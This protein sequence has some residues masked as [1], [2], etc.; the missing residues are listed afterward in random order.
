MSTRPNRRCKLSYKSGFN[1]IFVVIALGVKSY[2][3]A[4]KNLA[5]LERSGSARNFLSSFLRVYI[6]IYIPVS[7]FSFGSFLFLLF[8]LLSFVNRKLPLTVLKKTRK[9]MASFWNIIRTSDYT[10][11]IWGIFCFNAKGKNQ[12]ILHNL[13]SSDFGHYIPINN[14]WNIFQRFHP[15]HFG[16]STQ[17]LKPPNF[18][19][20]RF[21]G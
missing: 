8:F 4:K 6:F 12:I 16:F 13:Y 20:K 9:K 11:T 1:T 2:F 14:V 5:Q 3:S 21:F 7:S 18:A 10:N 19:H 15:A 17:P